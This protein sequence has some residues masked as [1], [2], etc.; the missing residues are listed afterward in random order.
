MRYLV[1]SDIHSNLPALKAVLAKARRIGYDKI[2][3]LGDFVG[4]YT[5][6]NEVVEL[7]KK[8]LTIAVIGNHDYGLLHP[9]S[10]TLHFN[11][12]AREALFYNIKVISKE[13]L[14]FLKSLSFTAETDGFLFVHG[15]PSEPEEFEYIY[16][17]VQ[18][19]RELRLTSKK[20]TFFGHTHIPVI[21]EYD[22]E[23]EKVITVEKYVRFKEG[24]RY[25]INPGSV[26]QPRDGNPEASF[27]ILDMEEG[28]YRHYRVEYDIFETVAEVIRAGLNP[29]LAERLYDGF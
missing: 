3:C 28:V 18:A 10:I 19:G 24:K 20:V 17:S 6:P 5:S 29:L 12:L 26:G 22:E 21:Y 7:I 11:E 13:T 4:Y 27:G 23:K 8:D 16:S 2:I 9:Q 1:I 14:E 15:S 25:L